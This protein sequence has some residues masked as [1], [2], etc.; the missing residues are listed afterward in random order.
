MLE[1]IRTPESTLNV[2]IAKE[3]IWRRNAPYFY[4]TLYTQVLEWPSLTVEWWTD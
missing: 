1:P 4:Q 3:L 2:N